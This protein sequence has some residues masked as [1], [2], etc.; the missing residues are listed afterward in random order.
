MNVE[1]KQC[2]HSCPFFG[3]N[4]DGMYCGHPFFEDK[5][6]DASMI[7]SQDNSR[8]RVPDECPLRKGS[9]TM[10]YSLSPDLACEGLLN[11]IDELM[12]QGRVDEA[13]D[14]LWDGIYPNMIFNISMCEKL[15]ASQ[16]FKNMDAQVKVAFLSITLPFKERIT[17]RKKFVDAFESELQEKRGA[18]EA[19]TLIRGLR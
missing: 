9:L 12:V 13:L 3:V 10:N 8:G 11:S 4:S 15:I 19:Y 6:A 1:V 18:R 2:Y 5:S 16:R 17:G 7:I 14:A